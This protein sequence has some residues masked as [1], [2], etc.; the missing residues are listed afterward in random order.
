LLIEMKQKKAAL[1]LK[2]IVNIS[3]VLI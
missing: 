1:Q 2:A 3:C